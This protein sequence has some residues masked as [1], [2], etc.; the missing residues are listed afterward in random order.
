MLNLTNS[1]VLSLSLSP[2]P[3]TYFPCTVD[4]QEYVLFLFFIST[5]PFCS[6]IFVIDL[7]KKTLI[8]H[9]LL[10]LC[11]FSS[12]QKNFHP[13]QGNVQMSKYH[14]ESVFQPKLE[15]N[16]LLGPQPHDLATGIT[17]LSLV[18]KMSSTCKRT[19]V[20]LASLSPSCKNSNS[21]RVSF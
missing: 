15:N 8:R 6:R 3:L 11:G 13:S 18:Q 16:L 1:H 7:H 4:C 10:F 20:V 9:N 21:S 5:R 2:S 12:K 19:H 17:H 14:S